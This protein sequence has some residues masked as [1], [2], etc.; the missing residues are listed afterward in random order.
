MLKGFPWEGSS[1]P[2]VCVCFS[3]RDFYIVHNSYL[4]WKFHDIFHDKTCEQMLT[5]DI[6]MIYI[7]VYLN[8]VN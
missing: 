8:N 4:H 5:K 6:F 1:F 2:S 7:N 3:C